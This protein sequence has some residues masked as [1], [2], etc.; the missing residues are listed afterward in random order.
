MKDTSV[1]LFLVFLPGLYTWFLFQLSCSKQNSCDC[2][3]ICSVG[4]VDSLISNH[5]SNTLHRFLIKYDI[6]ILSPLKKLAFCFSDK[7]R[8]HSQTPSTI[9]ITNGDESGCWV[10]QSGTQRTIYSSTCVKTWSWLLILENKEAKTP[11]E[12]RWNRWMVSSSWESASQRTYYLGPHTLPPV[13]KK[14][15]E[16]LYFFKKIL[17]SEVKFW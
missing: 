11:V 10:F 16:S 9:S 5:Y 1:L 3:H 15:E 7:T 14:A 17:N 4:D 2:S 13:L 8:L 12:M 6:Y